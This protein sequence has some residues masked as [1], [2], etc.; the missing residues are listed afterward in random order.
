MSNVAQKLQ[1][2]VTAPDPTPASPKPLSNRVF[3]VILDSNEDVEWHWTNTADGIRYVSGYTI[4]K[5]DK[6]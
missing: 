2:T 6:G 4:L 5:K 3:S 1:R